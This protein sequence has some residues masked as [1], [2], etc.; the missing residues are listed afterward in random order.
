MFI[1]KHRSLTTLFVM[2]LAAALVS[3][4]ARVRV[5]LGMSRALGITAGR[6]SIIIR[7]NDQIRE[8]GVIVR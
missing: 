8:R 1:A 4:Y 5:S 7:V 6:S 3:K 2:P